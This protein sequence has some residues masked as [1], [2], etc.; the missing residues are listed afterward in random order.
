MSFIFTFWFPASV[1]IYFFVSGALSAIQ[2]ALFRQD[3]FRNFWNMTPLPA[4]VD[5]NATPSQYRGDMK[6]AAPLSQSELNSRFQGAGE[7]KEKK[8][9]F[10]RMMGEAKETVNGVVDLGREK[11]QGWAKAREVKEKKIDS[12]AYEKKR[13]EEIRLEK[14]QEA[15]R[16][17]RA[18]RARKMAK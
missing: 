3:W 18:K 12:A 5:P 8:G 14:E 7:I 6:V 1:Q 15:S 2:S 4:R 17:K 13:R 11:S 9:V 10:G 16:S